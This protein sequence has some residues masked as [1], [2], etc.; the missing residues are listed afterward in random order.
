MGICP[1]WP[2]KKK[3]GPCLGELLWASQN[4]LRCLCTMEHLPTKSQWRSKGFPC[5]PRFVILICA[6]GYR[7][8]KMEGVLLF[9]HQDK[10]LVITTVWNWNLSFLLLI[11]EKERRTLEQIWRVSVFAFGW[12]CPLKIHHFLRNACH[13]KSFNRK[14]WWS[15]CVSSLIHMSVLFIEQFWRQWTRILVYGS[16]FV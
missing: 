14:L 7:D 12:K 10:Y 13:K 6:S 4:V 3:H 9:Y 8:P 1:S 11:E 16:N 15:T 2:M 5:C